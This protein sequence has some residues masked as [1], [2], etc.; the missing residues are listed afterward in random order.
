MIPQWFSNPKRLIR[1]SAALYMWLLSSMWKGFTWPSQHEKSLLDWPVFRKVSPFLIAHLLNE[2]IVVAD[3]LIKLCSPIPLPGKRADSIIW[4]L[5][6]EPFPVP[7]DT[8]YQVYPAVQYE[9]FHVVRGAPPKQHQR[10]LKYDPR[11]LLV[12]EVVQCIMS[13]VP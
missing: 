8:H 13:M 6:C 2:F 1:T 3:Y 4:V 9:C 5:F 7:L 10:P 11:K 12:I